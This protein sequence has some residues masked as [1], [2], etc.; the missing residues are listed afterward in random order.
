MSLLTEATAERSRLVHIQ[1]LIDSG[2]AQ[3]SASF[4]TSTGALQSI[5][6][7]IWTE[8]HETAREVVAQFPKSLRMRATTCSGAD[9]YDH[10][11]HDERYG[12]IWHSPR[13]GDYSHSWS[14]GYVSFRVNC[15]PDGVN[16]GINEAGIKRYRSF[17]RHCERLGIPVQFTVPRFVNAVLSEDHLERLLAA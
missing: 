9:Y 5:D 6:I 15:S 14:T 8:S 11:V 17:R 12:R 13:T 10:E 3:L 2:A 7:T 1:A 4:D 16:Q